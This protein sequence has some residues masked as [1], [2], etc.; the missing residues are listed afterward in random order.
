MTHVLRVY[1]SVKI[2]IYIITHKRQS[3]NNDSARTT[4]GHTLRMGRTQ[5]AA[6]VFIYL[7]KKQHAKKSL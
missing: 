2:L 3:E 7:H 5:K 4:P 1:Q 6:H